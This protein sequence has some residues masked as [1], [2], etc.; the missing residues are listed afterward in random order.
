M[1]KVLLLS[2]AV[3]VLGT[4][5]AACGAD[6]KASGEKT[7]A[8]SAQITTA[9]EKDQRQ[10]Y[11][12]TWSEDW[13]GLQSKIKHVTSVKLSDTTKTSMKIT[14]EGVIG[15]KIHVEN[16]SDK[17]VYS[18]FNKAILVA[19]GKEYKISANDSINGTVLK[20][21]KGQEK[22]VLL[23][24]HIPKM[25]KFDQF[26][27]VILKWTTS[28]QSDINKVNDTNSKKRLANLPLKK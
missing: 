27:N 28:D 18:F 23:N 4:T 20:L 16:T 17:D 9:K 5:L 21:D 22:D 24:F 26:D 11:V 10:Y 6:E 25:S 12:Q 19:D 3:L 14:A 8:K 7:T 13:R 15:V 1:K 2:S